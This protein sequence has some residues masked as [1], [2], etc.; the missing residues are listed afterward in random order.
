MGEPTALSQTLWLVGRGWLPSTRTPP[1]LSAFQASG[2]S[3]LGLAS[4][5][6][7]CSNPLRSKILHTALSIYI[8]SF[9]GRFRQRHLPDVY[10]ATTGNFLIRV[11]PRG[12]PLN[13]GRIDRV[14]A[15]RRGRPCRGRVLAPVAPSSAVGGPFVGRVDV[16][17]HVALLVVADVHQSAVVVV[18][19]TVDVGRSGR[20]TAKMSRRLAYSAVMRPRYTRHALVYVVSLRAWLMPAPKHITACSTTASTTEINENYH[21]VPQQC[22]PTMIKPA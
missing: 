6:P 12:T 17:R 11:G 13:T 4:P 2:F 1:R 7:E 22:K 8:R 19:E 16:G 20:S 10:V 18:V 21:Y 9:V 3:P 15:G 5:R 14:V